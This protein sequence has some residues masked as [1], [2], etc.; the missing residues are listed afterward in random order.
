YQ[1]VFARYGSDKPDMRFGL[2]IQDCTG[3][4]RASGFKIF[5]QAVDGGGVVRFL[6]VAGR[7]SRQEIDRLEA[8]VKEAGAKGL[9]W[10]IWKDGGA[11]SPIVKFLSPEELSALKDLAA[12]RPGDTLLFEA[13]PEKDVSA[14][15]GAARCDLI[16]SG[17]AGKPATEWNFTWVKHFPLLERDAESGRWTFSHNPFTA[18]LE[19]H[20]H[21]LDSDPGAALSHQYD[22]VVNGVELASGSIRNHRRPVQEKIFNLMGYSR[23]QMQERFGMLLDALDY[24]APPH[25]GIAFGFDRLVALLCKEDSIREVIAFP[26]TQRGTCPLSEAPSAVTAK[27]LRELHITPLAAA[28]AEQNQKTVPR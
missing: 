6:K 22:L 15:L 9:A 5:R 10:I 26:K 21:L 3:I 27:Q 16:R 7:F 18:P 4:F 1:E 23:E 14:Q 2:P 28:P 24:G 12:A 20:M 11:E 19:E 8:T 17:K 25:G 13:G